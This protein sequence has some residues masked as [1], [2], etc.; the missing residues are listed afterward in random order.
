MIAT[1]RETT[2]K[3]VPPD[4]QWNTSSRLVRRF[5]L[6]EFTEICRSLPDERLELID[7]E[8]VMSPPPDDVHIKHTITI[9]DLLNDHR[10]E[11][12]ALGCSAVGSGAWYAVPIELKEKWG[13][14]GVKGPNNVCPD[15]SVCFTDYL[16]SKRV[17]PA[18]L[19]I[20]VLSVSG[21][22]EIERDL[23]RKP[24]IYAALA[25]PAYW[26]VDR[27]DHSVWVHTMPA[28]GLYTHRA[29]YKRRKRLPAPGLGFLT[30][31][32]AQI[33]SS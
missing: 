10:Q 26:V 18:L 1:L 31:T 6:D 24:E 17:P 12:R 28:D 4:G 11:L 7:G 16:K 13:E 9:E 3:A 32:P 22:G 27:R 8:V 25:I 15:A 30:I 33:F 19:V 14:A 2:N 29:Q 21:P 5:T 20:E 23:I